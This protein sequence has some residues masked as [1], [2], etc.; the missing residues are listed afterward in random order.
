MTG[1]RYVWTPGEEVRQACRLAAFMRSQA[2]DDFDALTKKACDDPAWF[3]DALIRYFDFRF[4]RDYDAVLDITGGIPNARWCVGGVTNLALNCLDRYADTEVWASEAVVWEG[5]DGERRVWTYAELNAETC[6]LANGLRAAGIAKGEVIGIYMPMV[7]EAAAAFLAIAKIGAIA[8]PLFS[9]FGP[10]PLGERLAIAEAAGVITVDTMQR[11]GRRTPLK[12]VVDA[13]LEQ[14]SSVRCVVVMRNG[15]GDVEMSEGRDMWWH[16]LVAGLPAT[17]PTEAMQADDPVMLMFTS[18]TTGRPKGTVHTHIGVL[19]KN[20]LDLG[21]CID[22]QRGD[23]LLW[24]SDMGWIVGPKIIISATL[25]GATLVL[26]E[27]T[28][29]YPE[30]GRIWRLVQNHKVTICGISPTAVRQMMTHGAEVVARYDR[31]S[32]RVTVSTGEPWNPDAWDWFFEHVC[33]RRVP[34]LNYA[35]GTECG[36]AILIGTLLHPL[37]PCAFGCSAPGMCGDIVDPQGNAV[38]PDELGELIIRQP[39]IGL[40]RGL[41]REP[42]RYQ[43][44]YWG[45]I[46]GVWVQGDLASR[47]EDGLWYIHGR[48]DDTINVAG[49]RT[50]PAEIES[51][52]AGDR[53]GSRGGRRRRARCADRLGD[54]LRLHPRRGGRGGGG[55]A[56]SAA[57]G[58]RRRARRALPAETY[59]VR[60]RH[61]E[62]AKPEDHAPS[63]PGCAYRRRPRRSGGARQSGRAGSDSCAGRRGG[64]ATLAIAARCEG[65]CELKRGP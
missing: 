45:Q 31:S 49:K 13:A 54:R 40:T 5:E 2:I 38:A 37:K 20:A 27:G 25:T 57:R 33:E 14:A 1:G 19:A 24:M 10:Q 35:G 41:W 65:E 50:G 18:G 42:E 6:R 28:P 29:D 56:R 16:E 36:G 52:P 58:R 55:D 11:R 9:G 17:A 63:G 61:T 7:P 44:S 51:A 39:S 12:P 34:V 43:E 62:D 47:D 21:L 30:P 8:M 3:W 60:R 26:A 15:D 32:L 59:S 64:A 46:P 4:D 53:T 48:S 22:L 23:R